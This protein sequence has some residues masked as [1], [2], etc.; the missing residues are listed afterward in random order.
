MS[1]IFNFDL[2]PRT[3]ETD[4]TQT[5]YERIHVRGCI[6]SI[7]ESLDTYV[8][9]LLLAWGLIGTVWTESVPEN[10]LYYFGS[11]REAPNTQIR[12]LGI[13]KL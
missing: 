12:E 4:F 1:H 9:P 6:T 5:I 10:S 11:T 7:K 13:K 3:L 8:M 2:F